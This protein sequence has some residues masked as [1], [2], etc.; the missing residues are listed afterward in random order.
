[1][2]YVLAGRFPLVTLQPFVQK[3][4]RS[5]PL[6]KYQHSQPISITKTSNFCLISSQERLAIDPFESSYII[7]IKNWPP[8]CFLGKGG[9]PVPLE[10]IRI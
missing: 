3:K 5:E 10:L 9:N 1:M 2:L 6:V 4:K 8:E 7:V